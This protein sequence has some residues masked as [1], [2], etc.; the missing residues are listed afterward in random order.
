LKPAFES[1]TVSAASLL[2]PYPFAFGRVG[3]VF[4]SEARPATVDDVELKIIRM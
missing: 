1:V 4:D 2:Q 3:E